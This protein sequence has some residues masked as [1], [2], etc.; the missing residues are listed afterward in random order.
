[1]VLEARERLRGI[2]RR[3]ELVPSRTLSGAGREV[4][5]KTET[6]QHTGSFKLRGAYNRISRLTEDERRAGVVASSAGN[7][8][9]GV[10]LA[11]KM[12]GVKA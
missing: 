1:M 4:F 9:Q 10:A 3:T 12:F 7:H 2:V 11:A 5:L 6:L 8:A